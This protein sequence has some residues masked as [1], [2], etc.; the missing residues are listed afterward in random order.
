MFRGSS[1]AAVAFWQEN[2][3]QPGIDRTASS[4]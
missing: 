2:A 3:W 1:A 4:Q